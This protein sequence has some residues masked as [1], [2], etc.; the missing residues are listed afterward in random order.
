MKIKSTI[1]AVM[2]IYGLA[3]VSSEAAIL[4][5]FNFT[6]GSLVNSAAPVAGITVTNVSTGSAFNSFTSANGFDS[7]AQISGASAFFSGPTTQATAGNALVFTV[8]AA[9]GYEF[10]LD[11]FSFIARSALQAP[12]D[13]GFKIGA[14]SYD[15]SGSYS[16]DSTTTLISNQTLGLTGLTSATISIQGWN[17]TGTTA[18]VVDN[19]VLTGV[20]EPSAA[21]LGGLGVLALLRRRR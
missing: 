2:V 12:G 14:S 9:P 1:L 18:L 20:P 16:N 10:T 7:A 13:I 19:L 5:S 15:F 3:A 21:L 8:T 17:S 6:G 11:G 4:A